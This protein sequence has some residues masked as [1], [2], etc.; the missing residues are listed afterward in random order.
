[1]LAQSPDFKNRQKRLHYPSDIARAMRYDSL[2]TWER[3]TTLSRHPGLY[4]TGVSLRFSGYFSLQC[5]RY[6]CLA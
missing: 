1:M 6:S 5:S 4:K 2:T 3:A